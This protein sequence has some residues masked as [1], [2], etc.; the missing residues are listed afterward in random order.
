KAAKDRFGYGDIASL[1]GVVTGFDIDPL[2]VALAKTTWVITLAA[3]IK[4]A[5]E[6]VTIP[7]YH[8]DSLFAVTPVSASIP[9]LGEGDAID[10]SL[11]G[12]TVQLPAG[13]VQPEYRDLFDRIVDW[14]YD[15]AR[16]GAE[17]PPTEADAQATLDTAAAALGLTLTADLRSATTSALLSLARRRKELDETGL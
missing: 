13:L 10:I 2:A 8:A 12:E 15:E 17:A 6:P 7:I 1:R 3:E 4:G 9:M 16:S 14:A 11:D 5:A